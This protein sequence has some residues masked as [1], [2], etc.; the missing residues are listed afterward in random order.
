M[1]LQKFIEVCVIRKIVTME[2]SKRWTG[3]GHLTDRSSARGDLTT[4]FRRIVCVLFCGIVKTVRSAI[5]FLAATEIPHVREGMFN[6]SILIY[7]YIYK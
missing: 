2:A 4:P 5:P 6:R 7:I 3:E 1:L